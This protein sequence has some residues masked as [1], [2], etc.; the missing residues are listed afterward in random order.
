MTASGLAVY[1]AEA[2]EGRD[3]RREVWVS[4]RQAGWSARQKLAEVWRVSG[5]L[6]VIDNFRNRPVAVLADDA[7]LARYVTALEGRPL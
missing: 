7:E 4:G 5:V 1:A 3:G 2:R 6:V